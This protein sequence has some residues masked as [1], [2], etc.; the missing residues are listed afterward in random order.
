MLFPSSG[1]SR[2][3]RRVQ[4]GR[5]S[6]ITRTHASAVPST[7][8]R[9]VPASV[10][11]KEKEVVVE[12]TV[13]TTSTQRKRRKSMGA[14]SERPEDISDGENVTI[15]RRGRRRKATAEPFDPSPTGSLRSS[16]SAPTRN[17]HRPKRSV[18]DAL[19]KRIE[20]TKTNYERRPSTSGKTVPGTHAPQL[21]TVNS[22][23][24]RIKLIVREPPPS[25]SSPF[26]KSAPPS[27]DRSL[28]A[29]L[30]YHFNENDVDK[31]KLNKKVRHDARVLH[32]I[33]ILKASGRLLNPPPEMH[34]SHVTQP[35]DV[36]A[37]VVS[38]AIAARNSLSHHKFGRE[39][40]LAASVQSR[41][42]GYWDAI[43]RK[44]REEAEG[45]ERRVR[46]LASM[47]LKAISA[48]WHKVFAH[49]REQERQKE[50]AEEVRRGRRH[51]DAILD[52]SGQILE[53]QQLELVR[54]DARSDLGS[55]D[56]G[57]DSN[58]VDEDDLGADATSEAATEVAEESATVLLLSR[59]EEQFE[60]PFFIT[61]SMDGHD[62]DK[63]TNCE[64]HSAM[65]KTMAIVDERS[66]SDVEN[67]EIQLGDAF[68]QSEG[69]EKDATED[70]N[71]DYNTLEDVVSLGED[72]NI[73]SRADSISTSFTD[74]FVIHNG[75]LRRDSTSPIDHDIGLGTTS[76]LGRITEGFIDD[77]KSGSTPESTLPTPI[78]A[79]DSS[80]PHP[81]LPKKHVN[82]LNENLIGNQDNGIA[83]ENA[84]DVSL[85]I[86]KLK[87][88]GHDTSSG[89]AA[90]DLP[91]P[92]VTSGQTL[93]NLVT[94][95]GESTSHVPLAD[96]SSSDENEESDWEVPTEVL[97]Y[98]YTR[99]RWKTEAKVLPPLLLRGN[100]RPYQQSG[101][102]WL[103]SLNNNK[104]NGI[105]ADEMGLGYVFL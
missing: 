3:T 24:R 64:A 49:I 36:W 105:L 1:P 65:S 70:M 59:S 8:R 30:D 100:L 35:H 23:L 73:L 29:L 77:L 50:E 7:T 69:S 68:S 60:P 87:L 54:E 26:Q 21:P 32:R 16:V 37:N 22:P 93:S 19:N 45:E 43:R 83:T 55:S 74:E 67:V 57:S 41:V 99:V 15:S 72:F 42:I 4:T 79:I 97:P 52:Q 78:S 27:H 40:A 5:L 101:L 46:S 95:D 34:E 47:I 85:G 71:M 51:L 61:K 10:K 84:G 66:D 102:E 81:S 63:S 13:S 39:G 91:K 38:D 90:R 88:N 53:K 80:P 9:A 31:A 98:S 58:E 2:T 89:V 44:E 104:M 25:I 75:D 48:E 96:E 28:S 6:T 18:S 56:T 20:L 62:H 76:M 86:A 33:A 92:H 14:A 17:E 103:A 11:G 12:E 82:G 94:S